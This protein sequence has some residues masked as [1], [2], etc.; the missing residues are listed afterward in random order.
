[1]AAAVELTYAFTGTIKETIGLSLNHA[2]DP[3]V[4]HDLGSD[5]ATLD[6]SS[7]PAVTKC[8]EGRVT[9]TAGDAQLDLTSLTDAK[10]DALTFNGLKV[11]FVKITAPSTNTQEIIVKRDS[12][13]AYNLCGKDNAD[14]DRIG[15][16][17]GSKWMWYL[18]DEAEDVDA[19]HKSVDFDGTGTEYLDILLVAG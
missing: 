7:T 8:Y 11:Q 5:A 14:A 2:S 3:V 19:T 6:G 4:T 1:M 17:P 10:G 9:L 16:V 18:D 15:V 13:N 12:S